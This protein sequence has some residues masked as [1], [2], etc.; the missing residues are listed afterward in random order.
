MSDPPLKLRP[1][2]GS[3]PYCLDL[4][5]Y[6]Q[7]RIQ[8][9]RF[10]FQNEVFCSQECRVRYFRESRDTFRA[11]YQNQN[12]NVM[13]RDAKGT[14]PIQTKFN[15]LA[16]SQS[17]DGLSVRVT[18]NEVTPKNLPGA[19]S[20]DNFKS[21]REKRLAQRSSRSRKK[22]YVEA[23]IIG[24]AEDAQ[25]GFK[26]L[27]LELQEPA[28]PEFVHGVTACIVKWF[29]C[30]TWHS[31]LSVTTCQTPRLLEALLLDDEEPLTS[32]VLIGNMIR[33]REFQ[34]FTSKEDAAY[35]I[36]TDVSWTRTLLGGPEGNKV[37]RQ[38]VDW[39]NDN[40]TVT[41]QMC[42]MM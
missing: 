17:A 6:C 5:G 27:L 25:A 39:N 36:Q 35:Q 8:A 12:P 42:P 20:V 41:C 38:A 34:S 19:C 13:G 2:Q 33:M 28:D 3:S 32:T 14:R 15:P 18:Q 10:I 30:G 16:R 21:I 23:Q 7:G 26:K 24:R 37:W 22:D 40:T 31:Q 1:A 4:C 29:A 11:A 9:E